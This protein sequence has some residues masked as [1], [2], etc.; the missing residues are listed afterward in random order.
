MDMPKEIMERLEAMDK[1]PFAV[2]CGIELISIGPYTARARLPLDGRQNALGAMHG[3]ALFALA[4]QVFA[5]A[6]N[7]GKDVYVAM[8]ASIHYIKPA[9][10]TV[11][12]EAKLIG[13]SGRT[14]LFEVKIYQGDDLVAIF[15]A[16]GYRLSKKSA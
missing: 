1:A 11:E 16:T 9:I 13:K 14:A 3:G 5:L 10:D 2:L 15:Q 4:D 12:A 6:V 7:Q 8:N